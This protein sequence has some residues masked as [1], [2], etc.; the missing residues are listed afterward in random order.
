MNHN[1]AEK[2]GRFDHWLEPLQWFLLGIIPV[3]AMHRSRFVVWRAPSPP[4]NTP[5]EFLGI[6]LFPVDYL[7]AALVVVGLLRWLFNPVSARHFYHTFETVLVTQGGIVWVMLIVWM[8]LGAPGAYSAHLARYATLHTA[9]CLLLSLWLADTVRENRSTVILPIYVTG[10]ALQGGLAIAQTLHSGDLGLRWLGEGEPPFGTASLRA[11]GLTDNPNS[12]GGYLVVALFACLAML[13]AIGPRFNRQ[14]WL[15]ASFF[16]LV[17]MGLLTTFSRGAIGAAA[18][19]MIPLGI[20]AK[21]ELMRLSNRHRALLTGIGVLILAG[22]ILFFGPKLQARLSDFF[23]KNTDESGDYF[24]NRNF[25]VVD[26]NA[27][28]KKSGI[29]GVGANNLMLAI[30]RLGLGQDATRYPVHN[31]YWLI[32]AEQGFPGMILFLIACGFALKGIRSLT[33]S[34]SLI[35]SCGFLAIC[36]IMMLEF[37]F[38]ASPH[39]QVLLFVVLGMIWGESCK[40]QL[41]LAEKKASTYSTR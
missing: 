24:L 2:P 23:Q 7:I 14:M 11:Y 22:S 38:W 9:A 33:L 36:L 27:V 1:R 21:S 31:V 12:L 4:I 34:P 13:Y 5:V 25:Y 40:D 30:A 28:I 41:S 15:T 3:M 32:R 8:G 18:V 20:A 6:V 10:A 19:A 17:S 37:Y 39:S 26:T 16:L 35:W 29:S